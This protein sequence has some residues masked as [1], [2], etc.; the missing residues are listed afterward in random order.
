MQTLVGLTDSASALGTD[1]CLEC[2][3]GAADNVREMRIATLPVLATR[4]GPVR[5]PT[6]R[7]L[8]SAL[9]AAARPGWDCEARL[10]G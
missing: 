4:A 3:E 9:T 5:P 1:S 6:A 2:D 8:G 10:R 7:R